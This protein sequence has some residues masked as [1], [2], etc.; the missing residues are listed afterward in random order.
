LI[1]SFFWVPMLETKCSANYQV[2]E[3]G[4]MSTSENVAN[5]GLTIK[6]LF[7]TLNDGSYVF[8][9]GPHIIIMLAFSFF[10]FK[11]I[12]S[13]LKL[14]YG[15]CL[16]AGFITMWMSTKYFPWKFLPE[17]FSIIQFPWRMLMMSA[18]FFSIVCA[19]N[20]FAVIKKFNYKDVFVISVISIL[21]IMAIFNLLIKVN[22]NSLANIEDIDLGK[23]SGR[24]IE[25]VA[26]CGKG[27]YLT[28][29]AYNNRFYIAT[30]ENAIY[31]LKGKAIIDNENKDDGKYTAKIETL[32]A[33]YTVF[34]MPYVYYPGYTIK[35][36]G[37]KT[38]TFETENGLLGFV[39]GK[40]DTADLELTYT[41][42]KAMH[43]SFIISIIS[44]IGFLGYN[45]KC[46][47]SL[48]KEEK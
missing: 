21:Y 8:E 11:I 1:T 43:I 6:Q 41:G 36:D 12:R 7:V 44:C 40:E 47:K 14:T 37:I 3:E 30:R 15:F 39:M 33:E 19:I 5:N 45:I 32:D 16:I 26:G 46:S 25:T 28:T 10:T 17:Q 9:L 34:E 13:D 2:Y 4:M 27:E 48:K 22:D 42:T 38:S 20:M 35:L 18:F 31:V 29:N 23:F 24:E